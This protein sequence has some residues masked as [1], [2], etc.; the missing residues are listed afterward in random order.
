[1]AFIDFEKAFDR[2]D[3]NILWKIM[4]ERGYPQQLIKTIRCFYQETNIAK[5]SNFKLSQKMYVNQGVRQGCSLSPTLFN[6]QGVP[7]F[8]GQ[9]WRDCTMDPYKHFDIRD[10]WSTRPN[11]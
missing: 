6:I 10:L 8:E 11:C 1:M 5:K 7:E 4:K 9:N 2:V 3:R